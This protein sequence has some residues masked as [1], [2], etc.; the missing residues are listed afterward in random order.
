[1]PGNAVSSVGFLWDRRREPGL[2]G[3]LWGRLGTHSG[4]RAAGGPGP[5]YSK[6]TRAGRSP[7]GD[8]VDSE[9]VTCNEIMAP[10]A[11]P[12]RASI[13]LGSV[14]RDLANGT[15]CIHLRTVRANV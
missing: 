13:S 6:P 9:A 7:V 1:M 14:I 10:T 3:I 11:T 15:A 2:V 5:S 8:A 12:I 4:P